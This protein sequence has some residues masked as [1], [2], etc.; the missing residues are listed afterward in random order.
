MS[1]GAS[2]PVIDVH[3]HY[4]AHGETESLFASTRTQHD[5]ASY[6][7][8]E[9]AGRREAMRVI[10][11]TGAIIMPAHGYLRPGGVADTRRINDQLARYQRENADIFV[12]GLGIVEPQHG[13]AGLEELRRLHDELG[14]AGI[15]LHARFQGV[16]TDSEAVAAIIR[17]AGQ[18]GMTPFVHSGESSEESLWRILNLAR[19]VPDLTIVVLDGLTGFE[20]TNEAL[21]VAELAPNLVFDT[22]GCPDFSFVER[23][24]AR[25]GAGRVVFGTNTYSS[26]GTGH[27]RTVLAEIEQLDEATATAISHGTMARILEL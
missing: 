15:T 27:R 13:A 18:L 22:A 8:L 25:V 24:I 26:S 16:P 4:V 3:H 2:S 14:L 19:Q 10:G 7:K 9:I 5:A 21:V 1:D 17:Q 11:V 23:L 6:Q 12:A 20:Q